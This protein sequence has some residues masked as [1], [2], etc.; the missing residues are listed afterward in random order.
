MGLNPVAPKQQ[1]RDVQA[2]FLHAVTVKN[3]DETD[4]AVNKL[5]PADCIFENLEQPHS[6]L[7]GSAFQYVN[8]EKPIE[9]LRDKAFDNPTACEV[10]KEGKFHADRMGY[11]PRIL[12][13]FQEKKVFK[14]KLE[15]VP[16]GKML[17]YYDEEISR[18]EKFK[19]QLKL[20]KDGNE[21]I[22][23]NADGYYIVNK[24]DKKELFLSAAG[25]NEYYIKVTVVGGGT[26]KEKYKFEENT[27]QTARYLWLQSIVGGQGK[28]KPNEDLMGYYGQVIEKLRDQ[29]FV[30]LNTSSLNLM[31]IKNN[32]YINRHDGVI[33]KTE[34]DIYPL[35][36]KSI[37]NEILRNYTL[38]GLITRLIIKRAEKPEKYYG[39]ILLDGQDH[40]YN[41]GK[42]I[43]CDENNEFC[44]ISGT[45]SIARAD[46]PVSK[47][48]TDI[49]LLNNILKSAI[50]K[51][52]PIPKSDIVVIGGYGDHK[53]ERLDNG[54]YLNCNRIMI[55]TPKIF[56]AKPIKA[57]LEIKYPKVNLDAQIPGFQFSQPGT[58][59]PGGLF[60]FAAKRDAE[61]ATE[62]IDADVSEISTVMLHEIGHALQMVTD[63]RENRPAKT[64]FF[65]DNKTALISVEDL[66]KNEPKPVFSNDSKVVSLPG[67]K[68]SSG[69]IEEDLLSPGDSVDPE[70]RKHEFKKLQLKGLEKIHIGPHCKYGV[71][72]S[73][74]GKITGH[75][76]MFG[77]VTT[78][79]G[80]CGGEDL[81]KPKNDCT[82]AIRKVDLTEPFKNLRE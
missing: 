41:L 16:V 22:E 51:P 49:P 6:V 13:R 40:Y 39:E 21:E 68:S 10:N 24:G 8:F 60:V 34:K 69:I 18:N 74:Y 27:I 77:A 59:K 32:H 67:K 80:F 75:C 71:S 72:L 61:L 29:A 23:T 38:I 43:Y 7:K 5:K 62:L 63:G 31:Y 66:E 1:C 64:E 15:L 70:A 28:W 25:G 20:M 2:G 12:V 54:G 37:S 79:S 81:S 82:M 36:K 33:L 65:Y 11:K 3:I 4:D 50:D 57:K 35:F 52:I 17:K 44:D 53:D 19:Q 78:F 58:M 48:F 26:K 46:N 30:H 42:T 73:G 14:F 56:S 9:E 76:I 47:S 45:F 55:K